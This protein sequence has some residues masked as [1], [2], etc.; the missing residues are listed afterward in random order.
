MFE[1]LS[2]EKQRKSISIT[3]PSFLSLRATR[4]GVTSLQ[5]APLKAAELQAQK[6][7]VPQDQLP[8]P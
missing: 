7:H 3:D 2:Q 5:G 8:T 6:C 1:T 4:D